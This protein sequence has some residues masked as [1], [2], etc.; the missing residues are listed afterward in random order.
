[1]AA[2]PIIS[3]SEA[4]TILRKTLLKEALKKRAAELDAATT[5]SREKIMSEI[6]LDV[7]ESMKKH[8]ESNPG[9]G[10]FMVP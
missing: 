1:M 9:F 7:D 4:L 10:Q 5:E 2:A 3:R 8:R 6:D